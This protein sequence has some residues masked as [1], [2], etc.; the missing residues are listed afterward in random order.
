MDCAAA[1][2]KAVTRLVAQAF[3][4]RRAAPSG[5]Y[6]FDWPAVV[7]HLAWLVKIVGAR[8]AVVRTPEG[9]SG[10]GLSPD[11]SAEIAETWLQRHGAALVDLACETADAGGAS[12]TPTPAKPITRR[13][14]LLSPGSR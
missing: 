13:W 11:A 8:E 12:D 2:A 7:E 5:R 14:G 9:F 4:R 1:T 10:Y 3:V 6:S